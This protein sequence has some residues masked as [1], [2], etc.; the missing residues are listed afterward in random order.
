MEAF[1][2]VGTW[3]TKEQSTGVAIDTTSDI[4]IDGTIGA[5]HRRRS[6]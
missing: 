1:N 2:A 5:R 6:T 4:V 3:Q